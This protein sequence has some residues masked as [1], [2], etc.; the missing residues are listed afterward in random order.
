MRFLQQADSYSTI[1]HFTRT[2]WHTWADRKHECARVRICV[3]QVQPHILWAEILYVSVMSRM[4]K[5]ASH[6]CSTY[7]DKGQ[8]LTWLIHM[9]TW[10]IPMRGRH[11]RM[12]DTTH[13]H[14]WYWHI[15]ACDMTHT[16]KRVPTILHTLYTYCTLYTPR[17]E[18]RAWQYASLWG[19]ITHM[20]VSCHIWMCHVTP[21][22]VPAIRR[23][24]I[25]AYSH[26]PPCAT[27]QKWCMSNK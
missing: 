10:L 9:V 13:S 17:L 25:E 21:N 1:N 26:P 7:T 2:N 16:G 22:S 6:V 18:A 11:I 23:A 15:H 24:S 12:H 4:R 5:C 19:D 20:N 3:S 27:H 14:A 8:R